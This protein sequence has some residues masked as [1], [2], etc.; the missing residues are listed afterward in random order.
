ML[1]GRMPETAPLPPVRPPELGG[2][3]VAS[4]IIDTPIAVA[5]AA[6]A[7]AAASS[8]GDI[9]GGILGAAGGLAKMFAGKKAPAP[10]AKA[11][12]LSPSNAGATVDAEIAQ[13]RAKAPQILAGLLADNPKS[14]IDPRKQRRA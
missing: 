12:Q 4:P 13:D 9:L 8:G 1:A 14:L 7:A 6:P 2:I 3:D 11:P 5:D 10:Q